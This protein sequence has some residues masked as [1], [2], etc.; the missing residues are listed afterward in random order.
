MSKEN[1]PG[2]T[3]IMELQHAII[4]DLIFLLSLSYLVDRTARNYIIKDKLI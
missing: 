4:F 1:I 2:S 3:R